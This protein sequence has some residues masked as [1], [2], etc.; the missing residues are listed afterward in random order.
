MRYMIQK[1]INKYMLYMTAVRSGKMQARERGEVQYDPVPWVIYDRQ[2]VATNQ[3]TTLTFFKNPLGSTQDGTTKVYYDTNMDTAGVL[4]SPRKFSVYGLQISYQVTA[5]P[6]DVR[7]LLAQAYHEFIVGIKQYA[8]GPVKF[9]PSG[10]GLA[11]YAGNVAEWANTSHIPSV[12]EM[13]VLARGEYPITI[14]QQ[15]AF[16]ARLNFKAA[17]SLGATVDVWYK[18]LG[19]LWREVQ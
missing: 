4:P 15:Q 19:I 11:G 3:S 10:E 12:N 7:A 13:W 5:S 17:V 6:T 14:P 9:I 18:L 8:V 2:R 16:E 1:E